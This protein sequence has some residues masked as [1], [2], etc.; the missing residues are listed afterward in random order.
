MRLSQLSK[1]FKTAVAA[2]SAS[3][4]TSCTTAPPGKHCFPVCIT[5]IEGGTS[6]HETKEPPPPASQD[7]PNSIGSVFDILLNGQKS[8][9]TSEEPEANEEPVTDPEPAL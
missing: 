8:E 9:K 6:E 4:A 2:L 1:P 7:D 3:F 5:V